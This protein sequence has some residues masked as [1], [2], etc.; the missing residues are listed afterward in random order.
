VNEMSFPGNLQRLRK[1]NKLTQE[2][3]AEIMEIS[4]QAI[5]K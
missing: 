4:R 3:L 5:A 2:A 1:G